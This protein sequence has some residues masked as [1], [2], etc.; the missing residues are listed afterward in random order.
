MRLSF[1]FMLQAINL[2]A[3]RLFNKITGMFHDTGNRLFHHT[4]SLIDLLKEQY[5]EEKAQDDAKKPRS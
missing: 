5:K 3:F 1:N 2:C 4:E